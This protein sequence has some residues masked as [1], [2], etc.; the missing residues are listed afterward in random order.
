MGLKSTDIASSP[1]LL[2]RTTEISASN[3]DTNLAVYFVYI[4]A[5]ILI[6]P[7]LSENKSYPCLS[8]MSS[9]HNVII[10]VAMHSSA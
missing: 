9:F 2:Y 10:D 4:D 1:F 6:K 5:I 3:L 7:F 8:R